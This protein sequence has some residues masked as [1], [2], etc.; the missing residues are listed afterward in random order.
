MAPSCGVELR[1]FGLR[2][3]GEIERSLAAFSRESSGG[4]IVTGSG[5]AS[6][7]RDLIIGLAAHYRLPAIYPYR[8]FVAGGGLVSYGPD[9]D[10]QVR[11]A[12]RRSHSERRK[13][14][15]PARSGP[16]QIC[17]SDLK[18]NAREIYRVV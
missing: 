17:A 11:R 4:L 9:Q 6:V 12:V 15:R 5:L 18:I 1:P 14:C 8:F 2:D 16:D 13:A 3:P 10:D 7:H